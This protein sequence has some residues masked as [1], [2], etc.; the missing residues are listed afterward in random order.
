MSKCE[1]CGKVEAPFFRCNYCSGTFCV[2]HH[3]PENHNCANKPM[4]PPPYI[5]V[6]RGVYVPDETLS[7]LRTHQ[8]QKSKK[9]RSNFK[10]RN[11]KMSSKIRVGVI[12]AIVA[13]TGY[14]C[15]RTLLPATYML[16]EGSLFGTQIL[17][18]DEAPKFES[19]EIRNYLFIMRVG[20][21]YCL[22]AQGLTLRGEPI[23]A[24]QYLGNGKILEKFLAVA[25]SY[26]VGVGD[27]FL[28]HY[29]AS[30]TE[31]QYLVTVV[32]MDSIFLIL[33]IERILIGDREI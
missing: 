20:K 13:I 33:H 12:L 32:A 17:E 25:S 27:Y 16:I 24:Y 23:H 4:T 2:E 1:V 3:L 26:T 11:V 19:E 30:K 9:G 28:F 22:Y 5:R 14:F 10:S 29:G 18:L 6:K 15:V 8:E 21:D 31:R 7:E